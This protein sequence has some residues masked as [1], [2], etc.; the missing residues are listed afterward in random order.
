MRDMLLTL[1]LAYFR[2]VGLL[3]YVDFDIGTFKISV[4][5]PNPYNDGRMR[6][7]ALDQFSDVVLDILWDDLDDAKLRRYVPG[8]W[9]DDVPDINFWKG[10]ARWRLDPG[11]AA[12]LDYGRSDDG[13]ALPHHAT[14]M[15]V[16]LDRA[17]AFA[18]DRMRAHYAAGD[19]A[20]GNSW[21]ALLTAMA[22]EGVPSS[23][24]LLQ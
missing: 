7:I 13:A 2:P 10:K 15:S 24:D 19:R 12:L 4:M 3:G 14:Q 23:S 8:S 18:E 11:A 5:L 17:R 1:M 20:R 21:A 6:M 22:L 16:L 9:E